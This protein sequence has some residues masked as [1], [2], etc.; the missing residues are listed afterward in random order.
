MIFAV[1]AATLVDRSLVLFDKLFTVVA[2]SVTVFV[3]SCI[4]CLIPTIIVNIWI[5]RVTFTTSPSENSVS[6]G[7]RIS[8]LRGDSS[9][10]DNA[11]ATLL[12]PARNSWNHGLFS[13]LLAK[14]D[15]WS[16]PP[17]WEAIS[18]KE[19]RWGEVLYGWVATEVAMKSLVLSVAQL[20]TVIGLF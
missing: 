5:W 7:L 10:R 12:I 1:D 6:V 14:G 9:G 15:P 16:S 2:S 4:C 20:F 11:G 3:S 13:Y 8:S 19:V 18:V 17:G